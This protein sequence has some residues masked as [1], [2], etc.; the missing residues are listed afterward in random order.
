M[1]GG[2]T[3]TTREF[4]EKER[5]TYGH[6]KSERKGKT[7]TKKRERDGNGTSKPFASIRLLLLGSLLR[8]LGHLATA[9]LSLLY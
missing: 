8:S 4:R 5:V 9:L 1:G 2:T 3:G 7:G 6:G